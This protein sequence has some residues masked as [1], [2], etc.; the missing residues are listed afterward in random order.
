[1][2]PSKYHSVKALIIL[3]IAQYSL[4]NPKP[5]TVTRAPDP[6]NGGGE[7]KHT[8]ITNLI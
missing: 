7:D 6:P 4:S 1:M 3:I 8:K 2:L 5:L